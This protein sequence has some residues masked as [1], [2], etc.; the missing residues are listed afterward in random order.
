MRGCCVLE[1][2]EKTT[3]TSSEKSAVYVVVSRP[4]FAH[5]W[6]GCSSYKK[7]VR[8]EDKCMAIC[9]SK[10]LIDFLVVSFGWDPA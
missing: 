1:E 7:Q 2:V 3:V 5:V 8:P 4:F 10:M 9:A 6:P